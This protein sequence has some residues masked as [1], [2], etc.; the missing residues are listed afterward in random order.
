MNKRETRIAELESHILIIETCIFR[1]ADV[2]NDKWRIL[3]TTQL[4]SYRK[5]LISLRKRRKVK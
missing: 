5:E 2:N 3:M 4:K 1:H